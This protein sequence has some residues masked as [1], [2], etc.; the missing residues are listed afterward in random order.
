[1]NDLD[2][3]KRRLHRLALML[4]KRESE[5]RKIENEIKRSNEELEKAHSV[6]E[7]LRVLYA[8]YQ[9]QQEG[10]MS[11]VALQSIRMRG[12]SLLTGLEQQNGRV[13]L[14]QTDKNALVTRL[15]PELNAGE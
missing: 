6:I 12:D 7:R 11:S 9:E 10:I 13:N 14:I 3:E 5:K 2:K 15:Q 1:M 8:S 4:C